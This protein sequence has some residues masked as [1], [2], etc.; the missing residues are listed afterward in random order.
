[1]ARQQSATHMFPPRQDTTL[2]AMHGMHTASERSGARAPSDQRLCGITFGDAS[3]LMTPCAARPRHSE[4]RAVPEDPHQ[5]VKHTEEAQAV[6]KPAQGSCAYP[7]AQ[8]PRAT[9]KQEG[10]QGRDAEA[11]FSHA[12]PRTAPA[13][14]M[15]LIQTH[16]KHRAQP[17]PQQSM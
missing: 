17:T 11:G 10:F 5:Q 9:P 4:H 6:A 15:R 8:T 14:T 13:C 3:G 2:A 7:L 12:A 1:M 16:A